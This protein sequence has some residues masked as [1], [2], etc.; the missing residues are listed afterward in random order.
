M[1]IRQDLNGTFLESSIRR[2]W[3][4]LEVFCQIGFSDFSLFSPI[5]FYH[6]LQF[7]PIFTFPNERSLEYFL[8]IRIISLFKSFSHAFKSSS[9]RPSVFLCYNDL[10]IAVKYASFDI[11]LKKIV[12]ISCIYSAVISEMWKYRNFSKKTNCF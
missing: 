4:K 8:Q 7:V 11:Y 2:F 3:I 5:P 12:F 10:K 1:K 6:F 9:P